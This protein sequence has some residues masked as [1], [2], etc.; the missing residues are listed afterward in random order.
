M[1]FYAAHICGENEQPLKK[2]LNN[3]EQLCMR[4]AEPLGLAHTAGLIALLHDMGKA[5]EAFQRYL[6]SED[7]EKSPHAHAPI[8]AIYA[9]QRWFSGNKRRKRTAQT[10][11]LCVYGHHAGL[12]DCV[13]ERDKGHF[14]E[15][16]KFAKDTDRQRFNEA[17]AYFT[18]NIESETALDERFEAACQEL[19]SFR[20]KDDEAACRELAGFRKKD[21]EAAFYDG[22]TARLLLSMLVDAD[23]YDSACFEYGEDALAEPAAPIWSGLLDRLNAYT[24]A[25]F[26]VKTP[27][28]AIRADIAAR[29]ERAAAWE[30]GVYRLTVPTGGGKTLSSLRFALSHAARY[31][32]ERIFYV[33][34]FNTILDQNARDIREAL[35]GYEGLLEHH[36]NVVIENDDERVQYK[37][38][39]ERWDSRIIL[40]SMVQFLNALYRRENTNA[41]RMH[42]LTRSIIIFD[43]IQA[44]PPRCKVLFERAIHFLARYAGCTVLLCTAT[45]K[46]FSGVEVAGD[47][48]GGD[49]EIA[50]LYDDLKRVHWNLDRFNETMD[51]HQ[52]A[53][54]LKD[55]LYASGSVLAIVNTKAVAWDV[56][57]RTKA[58]L[59]AEGMRPIDLNGRLKAAMEAAN[60]E[61]AAFQA[62]VMRMA[63]DAAPEEVLCVH[64]STALCPAHRLS[65]IDFMKAWMK[66]GGRALCVS[67]A[68]IEAGINVSFPAVVRSLAGLPSIVQAGGRCN[69]H[70][71]RA[72]GEVYI[73]TFGEEKDGL[74]MLPDIRNGQNCTSALLRIPGMTEDRLCK[75][76][77]IQMYFAQE[78]WYTNRES[79]YPFGGNGTLV[80]LLGK[81]VTFLNRK[82]P[83]FPLRQA[84]RTA[85]DYFRVI[86]ENTRA[87]LVPYGEGKEIIAGLCSASDMKRRAQ[88]LARAQ[89]YSVN[90]YEDMLV[91][92]SDEGALE[93]IDEIG[94]IVLKEGYYDEERGLSAERGRLEAMVF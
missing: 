64:L 77:S 89:Q 60:G 42:S 50:K 49:E 85:G 51:N 34:P 44:L 41:R 59:C 76:E 45:Q 14:E 74:T 72:L 20:R 15:N 26:T 71:E 67:T 43:E 38:L 84:F 17:A 87:V 65:Y 1:N 30:P 58:L 52:A 7:G 33:I 62:A 48:M 8:G 57:E 55:L 79:K 23:R 19:A 9:Y 81:N 3:V 4:W 21:D 69:R 94:V 35:E 12:M 70:G 93:V 66:A 75:P 29:C 40:T 91:D 86:D 13:E 78:G 61:R 73:W 83:S 16:M 39:T 22:L 37:R 80:D 6:H 18:A 46:A 25:R 90:V 31:G 92:L 27:I 53:A 54:H 32:M 82:T 10:I 24:S 5:T 2:H 28:D 36:A 56:Y 11:A 88:L 68:L 47:L 63:N